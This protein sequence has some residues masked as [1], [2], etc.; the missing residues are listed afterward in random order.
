MMWSLFWSVLLMR[1]VV[2]M[3]ISACILHT[4]T[5]P[6]RRMAEPLNGKTIYIILKVYRE[7]A[8]IADAVRYLDHLVNRYLGVHA[9]IVGT[10]R[11]KNAEG[12]NG[13]LRIAGELVKNTRIA[14]L[15]AP[16]TIPPGIAGQLNY[17][18]SSLTNP[19]A[20][21]VLS[22]D[23]DGRM[24]EEGLE[25]IIYHV[26]NNAPV[27]LQSSL[28][29]KNFSELDVF[30]M[31]HA[32][33]QSRWTIAHEM[34]RVR[35]Y[36]YLGLVLAHVVGHGTCINLE[37]IRRYGGYPTE[38]PVEDIQLGFNL[39]CDGVDIISC[40]S[41]E[42]SETPRSVWAGLK[43][44]WAWSF[45]AMYYPLYYWHYE[46]ARRA[47][48]HAHSLRAAVMGVQGVVLYCNWLVVSWVICL[49]LWSGLHGS[50]LAGA[51]VGLYYA[52]YALAALG[53]WRL[54]RLSRIGV[55]AALVAVPTAILRR[56]ISANVALLGRLV[57]IGR[58]LYKTERDTV[59]I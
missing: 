30:Q 52:E 50:G 41:L 28:F 55:A 1:S 2:K 57:G 15:E 23:V 4:L 10:A 13:T 54:G 31:G 24:D 22:I 36:R 44:E 6:P 20:V 12:R 53:F 58:G 9:I 26:N 59:G 56:S 45:G 8:H 7:E 21:W 42:R 39:V 34:L 32:L 25:E 35:L 27:I 43:Q 29:L 47:T 19:E 49:A 5:K 14:I 48:G 51:F 40:N 18:L 17:A 33:L 37:I 16:E 11:E 38:T 3:T 46:R